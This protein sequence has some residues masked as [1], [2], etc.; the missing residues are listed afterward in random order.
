MGPIDV[1]S[2]LLGGSVKVHWY[3]NDSYRE[4]FGLV[5]NCKLTL[6]MLDLVHKMDL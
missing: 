5:P 1:G 2:G 6:L 3:E 4:I